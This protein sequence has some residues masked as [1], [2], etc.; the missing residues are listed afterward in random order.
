MT[1]AC[2]IPARFNS[3][4]FPGK[5]LATAL[6]KTVLERTFASALQYFPRSQLFVATDDERIAA[7]V[8]MLGGQA[9]FTSPDCP[10]GTERIAEA[11]AK[12]PGLEKAEVIVNLQGD[13][14]CVKAS[15]LQ[16]VVEVLLSDPNASMSTVATPLKNL[17]DFLSP[18]VVKVVVDQD[19]NALYFSRSPIPYAKPNILPS[20]ALHHIG[21]Y[22]FRRDY[23]LKY[24]TMGTTPLQLLED[25]EQL[26]ALEAGHRIKV[27]IVDE[28]AIA[29]DTPQDLVQ[30]EQFLCQ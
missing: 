11:V 28:Q 1:I 3:T 25:L 6:G 7:H 9:I 15:T 14:P 21:L 20:S 26:K 24:A 19:S 22:C 8:Q 17:T 5:L 18:H 2:I 27:A 4:R 23:L 13:H 16:A 30:L 10:N 12:F 29:V